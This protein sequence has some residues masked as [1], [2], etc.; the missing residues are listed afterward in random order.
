MCCC[1]CLPVCTHICRVSRSS[2]G[3]YVHNESSSSLN[4]KGIWGW[5]FLFG[6]AA[7]LVPFFAHHHSQIPIYKWSLHTMLDCDHSFE[8]GRVAIEAVGGRFILS[9]Y[10]CVCVCMRT[11]FVVW[12]SSSIDCWWAIIIIIIIII[13]GQFTE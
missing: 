9:L 1:Y 5:F 12:S 11:M 2:F 13:I 6:S 10:M 7:D 8:T 3:W 4:I